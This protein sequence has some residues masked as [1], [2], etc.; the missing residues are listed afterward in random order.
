MQNYSR[1]GDIISQERINSNYVTQKPTE[2]AEQLNIKIVYYNY[3]AF[4]GWD[5]VFV[6]LFAIFL[7]QKSYYNPDSESTC[8]TFYFWASIHFYTTAADIAVNACILISYH[9]SSKWHN[10]FKLASYV[11]TV[12]YLVFMI[13]TYATMRS[14]CGNLFYL[15]IAEIISIFLFVVLSVVFSKYMKAQANIDTQQQRQQYD[16]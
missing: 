10:Y 16:I 1:D 2:E 9:Y 8:D 11:Y 3:L 12:P 5:I 4:T 7:S 13:G 14:S 6:I 15:V